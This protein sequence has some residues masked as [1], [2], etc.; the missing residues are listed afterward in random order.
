[1]S[2]DGHSFSNAKILTLFDGTCQICTVST[3]V[4]C[5]LKVCAIH[6]HSVLFWFG[7][8][9]L[10][11]Q[12]IPLYGQVL[13]ITNDCQIQRYLINK[14]HL[15]VK[16]KINKLI[17]QKKKHTQT[18]SKVCICCFSHVAVLKFV[19]STSFFMKCIL[20]ISGTH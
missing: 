7:C 17:R 14:V 1:M 16:N 18:K 4:V 9:T 3:S 15:G 8:N 2:N 11:I 20:L 12:S 13:L 5:T 10:L 6:S 19:V